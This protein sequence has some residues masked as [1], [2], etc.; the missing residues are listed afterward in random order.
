M[1]SKRAA[2]SITDRALFQ[3]SNLILK[4]ASLGHRCAAGQTLIRGF[5]HWL[6]F[7]ALSGRRVGGTNRNS[8]GKDKIPAHYDNSFPPSPA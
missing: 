8:L 6:I 5:D 2:S 1:R 3:I 4:R 7:T